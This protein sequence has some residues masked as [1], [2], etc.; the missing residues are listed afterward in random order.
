MYKSLNVTCYINKPKDRNHLIIS[1]D[2]AKAFDKP[3][4]PYDKNP[5]EVKNGKNSTL[6]L[7]IHDRPIANIMIDRET[8]EAS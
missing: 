7:A 4:I 6:E 2:A 3:N 8:L 1:I 5:R